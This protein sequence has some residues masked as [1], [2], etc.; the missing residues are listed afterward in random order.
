MNFLL[1]V[2]KFFIK[3]EFFFPQRNYHCTTTKIHRKET[4]NICSNITQTLPYGKEKRTSLGSW[5]IIVVSNRDELDHSSH[6]ILMLFN[7]CKL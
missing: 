7:P 5:T 1:L 4:I 6:V 2:P 3:V